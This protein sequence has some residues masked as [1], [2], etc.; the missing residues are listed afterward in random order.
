M[1]NMSIDGRDEMI[2]EAPRANN[3]LVRRQFDGITMA[4]E[5]PATQALI[6]KET[7]SIQARWI[8][9]LRRP[10]QI[11][12]VRQDLI[13][14]CR[15]PG[16]AEKAIYSVP[17]GD[18]TIRG[19]TIRFAEVAMRCMTNMSA[20]AVTIFDTDTERLIR[21]TVTDFE[22]NAT[23]LRDVT[24]RK[25]IERKHLKRGQTAIRSRVNSYGDTVHIV[26]AT[27]DDVATKEGSAISKASRTAILRL[28]PGDL[29][30]E[31]FKL[32]ETLMQDKARK[33]PDGER[34][35]VMDAFAQ[36]NVKPT[37]LEEWLGHPLAQITPAELVEL[38]QLYRSL[39][40][41]EIDWREAMDGA[42]EMRERAKV[43]GK[44]QAKAAAA[45]PAAPAA[46]NGAAPASSPATN[47]PKEKPPEKQADKQP[48]EKPTG[49]KASS[50]GK[51]TAAV[52]DK[53]A[54][55]DKPADPPPPAA[56]AKP[57][58][59]SAP[60]PEGKE[61]RA[62]AMCGVPVD[63]AI[64]DPPGARCYACANS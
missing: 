44:A 19:L 34:K 35:K 13:A 22:S 4:H 48:S 15:R 30:D 36:L 41:G 54:K 8:M 33:D 61:E 6:A 57:Q 51:G 55:A 20:E 38:Q 9:A 28:I 7:A 47:A 52:K 64:G 27:E 24:V 5:G 29:R 17:R 10:R 16:F 23:W 40:E 58:P 39:R 1:D 42:E 32:C 62:C 25:T 31:M 53:I 63:V 37:Q 46:A 43:A 49:E 18:G 2:D 45:A 26:D 3:Q 11:D 59:V 14:E 50:S 12:Q 21:I 56:E 60:P